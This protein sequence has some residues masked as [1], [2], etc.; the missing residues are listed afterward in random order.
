VLTGCT[1]E[2]ET[3]EQEQ[4]DLGYETGQTI[5]TH[6]GGCKAVSEG[7]LDPSTWL[8]G[9]LDGVNRLPG[10]RPLD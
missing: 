1:S 2:A 3:R 7:Y 5:I 10:S 6:E 9:C 8:R 4:Y